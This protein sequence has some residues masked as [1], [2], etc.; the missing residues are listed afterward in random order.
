MTTN[1]YRT[2]DT[3]RRLTLPLAPV[4][5]PG[6]ERAAVTKRLRPADSL[7]LSYTVDQLAPAVLTT[8]NICGRPWSVIAV[9][10]PY[11]PDVHV[12]LMETGKDRY[13]PAPESIPSEEGEAVSGVIAAV[14]EFL[15]ARK[16]NETLHFGY[17][18]SPR[19]WGNVE[20]RGGFQ[21]IPTKWHAMIWGWPRFPEPGKKTAYA[22]W[23]ER[24]RMSYPAR[25]IFGEDSGT[26][27]F[28]ALILD[29]LQQPAGPS[30]PYLENCE[31]EDTGVVCRINTSL[32]SALAAPGFFS[33]FLIPAAKVLDGLM[34]ELTEMFTDIDC[35]ALD[36]VL[37]RIEHGPPDP[38]TLRDIRRPP[39]LKPETEIRKACAE[40][41]LPEEFTNLVYEAVRHRAAESPDV[42]Q[43]WR[44]GF[45]YALVLG[46]RKEE[47][48]CV[49][50]ILPGIYAG[51]GGVVEAQGVFL[52]RRLDKVLSPEEIH[53]KSRVYHDLA[54]Y[55]TARFPVY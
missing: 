45:G 24:S 17:N 55:L 7:D 10:S 22:D 6:E 29:R 34:R 11:S 8:L 16:E 35:A 52:K 19:S 3:I 5:K 13:L 44:K 37:K 20:E 39:R 38:R 54:A 23:I 53:I 42:E 47:N 14:L 49:L 31:P 26:K 30:A 25:R 48:S 51:P 12:M 4:L 28:A 40:K 36:A 43:W 46:G 18:W 2:H 41:G 50:R 32:T 27:L 21:S 9:Y 1:K 33:G 15:G